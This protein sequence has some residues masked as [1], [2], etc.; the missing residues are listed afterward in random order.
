[1]ES[2]RSKISTNVRINDHREPEA[3]DLETAS[4]D[5]PPSP[6]PP[7]SRPATWLPAHR[8]LSWLRLAMRVLSR[9]APARAEALFERIWFS[10][11]R[12]APRADA[13]RWLAAAEP[14]DVRVHGRRVRAWARGR[15][16]AV[17][18]V[19]G[20]S[21]H[22]GQMQPLAESL[23]AR[24]FRVVLFDAPAHG[25]SDPSR[26]GGRQVSMIEIAQALRV[27]AASAGPLAAVVAHSGGC[28][29]TALALRDGWQGP[30]RIVFVAPFAMP[31]IAIAP[32]GQAIG[33]SDG[34]IAAFRARTQARFGRPW[35][36][37]DIP[38]L[39]TRRPLPPLLVVHDRDDHDVPLRHGAALV[40]SWP[41]SRLFETR[42]LGH[43]RVLRDPAVMAEVEGFLAPLRDARAKPVPADARDELDRAVAT[44]P[45]A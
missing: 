6:T 11:R 38:A 16:P 37:F 23:Q 25:R 24:G 28:T 15:G 34:V 22:G 39:A 41:G 30:R 33:A 26:L 45:V 32:F 36:D 7:P 4:L 13:A 43:R 12:T 1:M 19:H 14:L 40:R 8:S 42:S 5:A 44:C 21:G 18:L 31:S 29:A 27:V 20:W 3:V 10:A 17:L 9:W 35:S 2:S